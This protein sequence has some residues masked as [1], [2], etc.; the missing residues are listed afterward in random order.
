[1]KS[2]A[3]RPTLASAA[4]KASSPKHSVIKSRWL[5]QVASTSKIQEWAVLVRQCLRIWT[6]TKLR[7]TCPPKTMVAGARLLML[8]LTRRITPVMSSRRWESAWLT[9]KTMTIRAASN[10]A[11]SALRLLMS[12]KKL[13]KLSLTNFVTSAQTRWEAQWP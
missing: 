3:T 5:A 11:K 9:F 8:T 6:L 2:P 4:N 12:G 1:M 7:A 10:L 13:I